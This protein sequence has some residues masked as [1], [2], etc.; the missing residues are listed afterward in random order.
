MRILIAE[1][2]V[3][4]AKVLSAILK[5]NN[6]SVDAV[7]NGRDAVDY[8]RSGL[9]DLAILDIMM[10]IEDG[11]SALKRVR[12]E[13]INIPIIMLTAKSELDDKITGLDSGADDYITKPFEAKELLARIRAVS[14]RK[15]APREDVLSFGNLTLDRSAYELSVGENSV[16]LGNKEFQIMELFM[17]NSGVVFSAEKIM[18]KIWDISSEA[19]LSVLWVY[20][21][22]LRKKLTGLSSDVNIKAVRGVGYTLEKV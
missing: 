7:H 16:K 9:Y 5:R 19:E 21:S 11:V 18:E 2:E 10:P 6:Y 1:D 4:L 8:I 12:A 17:L 3:A 22:G 13:G 20:V 14:R 15:D